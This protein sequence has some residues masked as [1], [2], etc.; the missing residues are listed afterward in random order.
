MLIKIFFYYN[1]IDKIR[2]KYHEENG[3]SLLTGQ[4]V[5]QLYQDKDY[6]EKY[7]CQKLPDQEFID[8]YLMAI[9]SGYNYDLLVELLSKVDYSKKQKSN[10]HIA[11]K[12]EIKF[13]STIVE[14]SLNRSIVHLAANKEESINSY[15]L[16]IE[17]IRILYCLLNDLSCSIDY[18]NA[19]YDTEFLKLLDTALKNISIANITN[20]FAF[21]TKNINID[22]KNYKVL[23]LR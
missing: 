19:E 20:L 14:S 16:T 22:Y 21:T 9:S 23:D 10:Y 5:Y 18:F 13:Y 7:Y 4:K 3:Y 2:K 11:S 17:K 6:A 8:L 15:Y 12:Q 1:L